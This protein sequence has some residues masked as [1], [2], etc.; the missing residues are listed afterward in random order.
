MTVDDWLKR[1]SGALEKAGIHTARLDSLVLLKDELRKDKSWILA[2]LDYELTKTSA[3]RLNQRILRRSKHE[4]LAYIRGMSEFYGREF[5]VNEHTLEPRPETETMIELLKN[6][7]EAFDSIVDVGTGSGVIAI[8]VKF[9]YPNCK[10]IAIDI[11]TKCIQVA[12]QNAL[13]H[14]VNI[15]LFEGNLLKPINHK[16]N[17]WIICA[18]LPYVPNS[19]T[20]NSA[21]MFEPTHAIFG[22]ED[23]LD[24]YRQL[25][26]QLI[27]FNHKP[28]YILTESLPFQHDELVT[29]AGQSGYSISK[30]EDFIQ[31]FEST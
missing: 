1:S 25:F 2:N 11:D 12:K 28:L 31:V 8:S 26:G 22:G 10:V 4:P 23:G 20:I 16:L 27:D 3:G 30:T 21:A 7:P 19:H 17:Q 13:K 18:N 24:Y 5:K 15:E 29:I 9:L 14:N 6:L